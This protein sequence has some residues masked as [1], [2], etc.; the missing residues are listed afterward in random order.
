MKKKLLLTIFV[1]GFCVQQHVGAQNLL[2]VNFNTDNSYP[3][4]TE[5]G[6]IHQWAGNGGWEGGAVRFFPPTYAVGNGGMSAH[7]AYGE[8]NGFHL[9]HINVRFLVKFGPEYTSTTRQP[10]GVGIQNKFMLIIRENPSSTDPAGDRGML[11]LNYCGADASDDGHAYYT[12]ALGHDEVAWHEGGYG[13]NGIPNDPEHGLYPWWPN[14]SDAF[15][16]HEWSDQWVCVE[17]EAWTDNGGGSRV[18]IWTQDKTFN[19]LYLQAS[20]NTPGSF[21]DFIQ[22]VGGFYNHYHAA[23]QLN[24][25]MFDEFAVDNSFIGPPTGFFD[26]PV[27]TH[28]LTV[29]NG[30]G[31]GDYEEDE[32]VN[33][34]PDTPATGTTFDQWTGDIAYVADVDDPTTTVTMPANNI[35]VTATFKPEQ[36]EE[37]NLALNKPATSSGNQYPNFPASYAVDGDNG[38]T[39][40]TDADGY[41]QS[42]EVDLGD[43]YSINATELICFQGRAYKFIVEVKSTQSGSYTQVVDRSNNTDGGTVANPIRD[44][45]SA[46]ARYVKIT[47]TGCEQS[48]NYVSLE[49]FRVF[50][51]SQKSARPAETGP[52][53]TAGITVYPNPAKTMLTIAGQEDNAYI[54][55]YT[56]QGSKIYESS[57]V[58]LPYQV[59]LSSFQNGTYVIKVSHGSDYFIEK[60]VKK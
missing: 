3:V 2:N 47:V 21:W 42:L 55:I 41:P 23:S 29:E 5:H 57:K 43:V 35:T 60:V 27:N 37:T 13:I 7:G 32:V 25:V 34:S 24:Y 12:F 26:E 30:T 58:M 33:I 53:A 8:G 19:G 44:E 4:W 40:S 6:A 17:Y 54:E 14:G 50:G 16:V 45:F 48:T 51:S 1:F 39:W 52:L 20:H 38:T 15:R 49:E 10:A 11:L 31:S 28:T 36:T 46:T 22:A 56:L 59:D 9:T 18:Y